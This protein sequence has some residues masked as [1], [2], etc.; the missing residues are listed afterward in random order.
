MAYVFLKQIGDLRV[1]VGERVAVSR[2]KQS[3]EL[4]QWQDIVLANTKKQHA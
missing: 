2:S 4:S 1:A 3:L